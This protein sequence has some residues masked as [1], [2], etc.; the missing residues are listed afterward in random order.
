MNLK[1]YTHARARAHARTHTHIHTHTHTHTHTQ[2]QTLTHT[3]TH[4][5]THARTH[6][7]THGHTR[8]HT[9]THHTH[10]RGTHTYTYKH[11]HLKDRK[12]GRDGAI[13]RRRHRGRL[14]Y[15]EVNSINRSLHTKHR[16]AG[17]V[18]KA[19]A[20]GA[21]EPGL[22]GIFPGRVIPVTSKLALQWPPC[23]APGVIGSVLGLVGP[24]SVY[25]DLVR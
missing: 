3:H 19:S 11:A 24:V 16:L 15:G 5:H 6:A 22:D 25:C 18:V 17:R 7:H 2:T 4:T 8:A 21:E 1:A 9:H 12:A 14:R 20:S 23:Q 13:E 10:A